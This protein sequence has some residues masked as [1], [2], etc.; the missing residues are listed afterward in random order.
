MA[1][2]LGPEM[3][4]RHFSNK[5]VFF[6]PKKKIRADEKWCRP[7]TY[8]KIVSWLFSGSTVWLYRERYFLQE[9][10]FLGQIFFGFFYKSAL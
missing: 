1:D 4:F 7:E 8:R 3:M 10:I 9:G 2:L 6:V 5:G